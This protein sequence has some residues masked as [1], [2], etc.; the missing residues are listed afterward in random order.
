MKGTS[1]IASFP[2]HVRDELNRRLD[3]GERYKITLEWLNALPEVQDLLKANFESQPVTKQNLHTWKKSGFH[4]WKLAQDA[5]QFTQES[6]PDELDDAALEKMSAKLIRCLQ[7]RYAALAGSLPAASDD[8]ESQ[9]RLLGTLCDSVTALRRGDLSAARVSLQQKRLAMEQF[10]TDTQ[11]EQEFWEW[12]KRPDIQAKLYPKRD[13]L[14]I[15]MEVER[16]LNRRLLG[17]VDPD[18]PI[19][20]P[21]PAALI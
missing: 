21:D 11:K 12:T 3:N 5:L 7:I 8:P 15:R 2:R 4:N 18:D 17:I 13:P 1:K 19:D 16:M 9:L 6:L 20:N 10:Q 14:K